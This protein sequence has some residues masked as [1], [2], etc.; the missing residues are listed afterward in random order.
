MAVQ[1]H[2]WWPHLVRGN[3]GKQQSQG[4]WP[5]SAG[6][7]NDRAPERD[8]KKSPLGKTRQLAAVISRLLC[9]RYFSYLLSSGCYG[10]PLSIIELCAHIAITLLVTYIPQISGTWA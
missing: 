2:R 1:A 3:P 6:T 5:S 7:R 10:T 8:A 9:D 4:T